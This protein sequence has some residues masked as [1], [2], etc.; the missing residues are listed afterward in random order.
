MPDSIVTNRSE[1]A[2][3]GIVQNQPIQSNSLKISQSSVPRGT[4]VIK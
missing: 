1:S 3:A 4:E 2:S